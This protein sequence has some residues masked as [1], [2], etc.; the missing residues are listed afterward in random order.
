MQTSGC[1]QEVVVSRLIFFI[2][3]SSAVKRGCGLILVGVFA[4]GV[5]RASAVGELFKSIKSLQKIIRVAIKHSY[6]K[7]KKGLTSI[8]NEL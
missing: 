2:V 7:H 8:L 6:S 5:R 4:C 3:A 1:Q